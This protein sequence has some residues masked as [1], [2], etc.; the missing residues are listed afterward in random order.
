LQS[1]GYPDRVTQSSLTIL[2]AE[3]SLEE[4]DRLAAGWR[5]YLAGD[6]DD[7]GKRVLVF[8]PECARQELNGTGNRASTSC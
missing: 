8:Y 4:S 6:E 5:A 7:D 2:R 1:G 3:C